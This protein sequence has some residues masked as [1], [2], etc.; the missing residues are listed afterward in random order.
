MAEIIF[1]GTGGS[2]ATPERD[3]T[4]L[5][6]RDGRSLL[7]VDCPGS[8][9]QKLKKLKVVPSQ[10]SKVLLTHIHP[11]HVYGWPSLIHSLILEEGEVHLY[12]SAPAVGLARHLLGLFGLCEKRVKTR[13]VF[14]ALEPE[15]EYHLT[16]GWKVKP[17]R[18]PHHASSFAYRLYL[19][20][21]GKEILL[22][23]DTPL[24]PP[25]FEAAQGAAYLVHDCAAP[26]WV[27]RKYPELGRLHTHSLDLGKKC[28]EVGVQCLIPIHF[29]GEVRFSIA[30]IERE[31]RK[32]FSGR[33]IVPEDL[34]RLRL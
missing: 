30:M 29:L 21:E 14:K 31:I 33:L 32:H 4:S 11:D 20:K 19:N 23:G 24:Y 15:R 27:F 28:Q 26:S 1:I 18:V 2:V 25:L 12:G 5:L 9:V 17:F 10:V 7:L 6:F 22:S 3:N 34:M 16:E 13:V 8:I